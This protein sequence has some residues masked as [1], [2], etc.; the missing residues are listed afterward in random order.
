MKA[1]DLHIHL[2]LALLAYI[3]SSI[4]VAG[5]PLTVT[6]GSLSL[7]DIAASDPQGPLDEALAH[8]SSSLNTS[9]TTLNHFSYPGDQ[10]NQSITTPTNPSGLIPFRVKDSPVTLLFHSFGPSI[11][12]SMFLHAVSLALAAIFKSCIK[13]HGTDPIRNG[14][15][16]STHIM[17]SG[18][19]V[20]ISV[21]DFR[22]VGKPMTYFMLRDTLTNIGNFVSEKKYGAT[23]LSYEIEVE[24]KGYVGTGHVDF[25]AVGKAQS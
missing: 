3:G 16:I 15:F 19:N 25:N 6:S 12:L 14:L 9:S 20:T 23:T 11:P 10:S 17:P 7:V 4:F 2:V 1:S 13:N 22:E 21:A 8:F 5:I 18:D 24:G